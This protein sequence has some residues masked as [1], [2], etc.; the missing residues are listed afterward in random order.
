MMSANEVSE[1]IYSVVVLSKKINSAEQR[2]KIVALLS[3]FMPKTINKAIFCQI[4]KETQF[5][6]K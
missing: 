6:T 1:H 4:K 2:M 5:T 3:K